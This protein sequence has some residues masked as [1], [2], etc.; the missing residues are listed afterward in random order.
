MPD[1]IGKPVLGKAAPQHDVSSELTRARRLHLLRML[2]QSSD[3][4]RT[5]DAY[6]RLVVENLGLPVQQLMRGAEV[7]DAERR[8]TRGAILGQKNTGSR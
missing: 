6:D 1:G 8:A 4:V 3:R 7:R 2:F 5:Q